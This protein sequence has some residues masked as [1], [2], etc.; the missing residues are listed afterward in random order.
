MNDTVHKSATFSNGTEF[1]QWSSAWCKT[2]IH[3]RTYREGAGDGHDGPGCELILAGMCGEPVEEWRQG[4]L[5]SPQTVVY[6]TRY[7]YDSP[8]AAESHDSRIVT[9]PDARHVGLLIQPESANESTEGEPESAANH[10]SLC[11]MSWGCSLDDP[12][13]HVNGYYCSACERSCDCMAIRNVR[14]DLLALLES[15]WTHALE[16]MDPLDPHTYK[17]LRN[18]LTGDIHA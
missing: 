15:A 7:E 17:V 18:A 12:T 11:P 13:R 8:P 14:E 5:W 16:A 3:D 4:P 1:D 2:C 10:D 9:D 6:C